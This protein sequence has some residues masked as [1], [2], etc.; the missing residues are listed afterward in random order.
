[1]NNEEL[2]K[3][4]T[5]NHLGYK[6]NKDKYR[7]VTWFD[8]PNE[9]MWQ[10]KR[11]RTTHPNPTI[12][13]RNEIEQMS[14]DV[15]TMPIHIDGGD[16]DFISEIQLPA[17]LINNSFRIGNITIHTNYSF[18]QDEYLGKTTDKSS[19]G[20]SNKYKG[21][22]NI[23]IEENG[24]FINVINFIAYATYTYDFK[25]TKIHYINWHISCK[26]K[27][28]D[29]IIKLFNSINPNELEII[30]TPK[31]ISSFT[32]RRCNVD[33]EYICNRLSVK[34]LDYKAIIKPDINNGVYKPTPENIKHFYTRDYGWDNKVKVKFPIKTLG[35]HTIHLRGNAHF[36]LTNYFDL[37]D[38]KVKAPKNIIKRYSYEDICID[39]KTVTAIKE[40]RLAIDEKDRKISEDN[41][42]TLIKKGVIL[43]ESKDKETIIEFLEGYVPTDKDI[44]QN[45]G[46]SIL[47]EYVPILERYKVDRYNLAYWGR[48]YKYE[49]SGELCEITYET[50]NDHIEPTIRDLLV[51]EID[52]CGGLNDKLVEVNFGWPERGGSIL[53]IEK[54][55]DGK[56]EIVIEDYDFE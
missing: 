25:Q 55:K 30:D 13:T 47:E 4:L 40:E 7:D 41:K 39:D 14:R 35:V 29:I 24:L 21:V 26:H 8:D 3:D 2:L 53:I 36:S 45:Y 20:I 18:S 16:K 38:I 32:V 49:S 15:F 28:R 34:H 10:R 19:H 33:M 1:M 17:N 9:V 52:N 23:I 5:R 42:F 43:F 6:S 50:N 46:D 56:Y 48:F 12:Y 37:T 27:C 54:N 22:L 44:V 51:N 11:D 31:E